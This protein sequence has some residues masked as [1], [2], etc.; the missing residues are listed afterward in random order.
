M[1]NCRK[2]S[3]ERTTG[4]AAAAA[5]WPWCKC[6]KSDDNLID[7]RT[8][9][10]RRIGWPSGGDGD[11]DDDDASPKFKCSTVVKLFGLFRF[12]LDFV[13]VCGGGA[14]FKACEFSGVCVRLRYDLINR[15]GSDEAESAELSAEKV[16]R[17]AKF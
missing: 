8:V 11:D 13:R 14:D 16:G 4:E 12:S 9:C 10:C 3:T 1:I 17:R 7:N 6:I 2:F 15:E 5:S